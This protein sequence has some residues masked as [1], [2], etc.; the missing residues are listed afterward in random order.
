MKQGDSCGCSHNSLQRQN[1]SAVQ[2]EM[3]TSG[4]VAQEWDLETTL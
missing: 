1:M 2:T 3:E 4:H